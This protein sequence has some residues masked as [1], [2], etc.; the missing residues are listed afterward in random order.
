MDYIVLDALRNCSVEQIAFTYDIYCKWQIHLAKRARENFSTD[1]GL[2]LL[3]KTWRGFVPKLHL[4]AHGPSC[5]TKWSLNYHKGVGRTDGE[6]TKRDWAAVV[7]AGLQ[8]AEMNAAARQA[9]LDDHWVD[10]NFQRLV[11]LGKNLVA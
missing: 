10:R 11:G 3:S 1:M 2:G 5:C 7:M 4:Y 8:T 6:L 9:A